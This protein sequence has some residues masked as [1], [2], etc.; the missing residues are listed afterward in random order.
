MV[1]C[2]HWSAHGAPDTAFMRYAPDAPIKCSRCGTEVVEVD[3]AENTAL[4][5]SL[6][7]ILYY[8]E[9]HV[10][11]FDCAAEIAAAHALLGDAAAG[12]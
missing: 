4:R 8:F 2:T 5:A 3:R 10:S 7:Q 11:E 9:N 12:E 1:Q 6:A